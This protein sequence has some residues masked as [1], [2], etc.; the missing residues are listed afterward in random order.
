MS[1]RP[2]E[3]LHPVSSSITTRQR[4]RLMQLGDGNLSAGLRLALEQPTTT[5][6]GATWAETPAD[7]PQP[8]QATGPAVIAC[9][10]GVVAHGIGA[11]ALV[12]DMEGGEILFSDGEA[13]TPGRPLDLSLLAGLAM[14]LGRAVIGATGS[15]QA[16][17]LPGGLMVRRV[18]PGLL[19]VAAGRVGVLLPLRQALQLAAEVGALLARSVAATQDTVIRLEAIAAQTQATA[20]P[21]VP[22]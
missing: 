3:R 13:K 17:P 8:E 22:A 11:I 15:D 7:L 16:F 4:D 14:E 5:A 2:R 12:I 21:E 19:E 10:V 18:A 6:S 20:P 9:P 1:R